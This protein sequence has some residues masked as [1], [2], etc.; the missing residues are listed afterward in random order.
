MQASNAKQLTTTNLI[1][2]D[3]EIEMIEVRVTLKDGVKDVSPTLHMRAVGL[4]L[5]QNQDEWLRYCIEN[6]TTRIG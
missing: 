6:K 4:F 3:S 2:G 1:D 5:V